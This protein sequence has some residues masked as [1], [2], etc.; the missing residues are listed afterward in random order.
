V[1]SQLHSNV[2]GEGIIHLDDAGI[3]VTDVDVW[4]STI[5]VTAWVDGNVSPKRLK[6]VGH[7]A[8]CLPPAA[9]FVGAPLEVIWFEFL[10]WEV[11]D[12]LVNYPAGAPATDLLHRLPAGVTLQ[13][14]VS[15]T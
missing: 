9:A 11:A 15:Y 8:L 2:T 1:P 5:P 12:L 4:V 14:N 13:I 10:S 7:L 6:W 3:N